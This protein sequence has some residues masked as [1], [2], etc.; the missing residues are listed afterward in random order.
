MSSPGTHERFATWSKALERAMKPTDYELPTPLVKANEALSQL[1][2]CLY[3]EV[4]DLES[5]LNALQ[6]CP[7]LPTA[8]LESL[9]A[10]PEIRVRIAH[11]STVKDGWRLSETTVEW[12]GSG[13]IPWERLKG[14]QRRAHEIGHKEAQFRNRLEAVASGALS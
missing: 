4:C 12:T 9:N 5:K 3:T 10:D 2:D 14:V 1:V 13:E 7:E 8:T 6:P 11:A